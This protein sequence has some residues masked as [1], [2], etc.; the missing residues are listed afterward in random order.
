MLFQDASQYILQ[1]PSGQNSNQAVFVNSNIE[2]DVDI[3]QEHRDDT[4][5]SCVSL[6]LHSTCKMKNGLFFTFPKA[7]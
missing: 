1:F 6:Y 5:S 3:S 2:V 4:A 7:E